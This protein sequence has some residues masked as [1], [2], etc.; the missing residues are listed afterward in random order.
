MTISYTHLHCDHSVQRGPHPPLF[1]RVDD[2]T[3]LL[4]VFTTE[5]STESIVQHLE[6]EAIDREGLGLM[7][8]LGLGLGLEIGQGQG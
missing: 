3:S 1:R 6:E 7:L 8:G 4:V 2:S 5:T